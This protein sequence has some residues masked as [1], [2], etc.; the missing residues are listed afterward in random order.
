M[1]GVEDQ[2]REIIETDPFLYEPLARGALNKSAAARW[3]LENRGVDAEHETIRAAI[4]EL[5]AEGKLEP[6][7]RIHPLL[8]TAKLDVRTDLAS[9]ELERRNGIEEQLLGTLRS[10]A[11]SNGETFHTAVRDEEVLV[12]VRAER[13]DELRER[14]DPEI[15]EDPGDE[16]TGMTLTV[17]DG[18][19]HGLL[20][21]VLQVLEIADVNVLT[22]DGSANEVSVV[23]PTAQH[24]RAVR[25]VDSFGVR[26]NAEIS[27]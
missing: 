24:R 4:G 1:A 27:E 10:L 12:V 26:A 9:V 6:A 3:I 16:L 23:V 21:I 7:A 17:D 15:V 25:V 14:F 18:S 22:V 2:V 13:V 5:E 8:A 19:A 11:L 20:G